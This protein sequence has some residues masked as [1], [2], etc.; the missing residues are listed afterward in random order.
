MQFK[1]D[2]GII[3]VMGFSMNTAEV[4]DFLKKVAW[5]IAIIII[6]KIIIKVGN[7]L[8][9][10]FFNKQKNSRFGV[11]EKKAD[12]LSELL[13]S[14]LRYVMYLLAV[15]WTISII[16]PGFA[17]T[18]TGVLG[19]GGVAV[20]FGAQSLIKDIISGFF[21]LFEDQFAVGDY[22]QVDNMSGFVETLG[23]R[24]TKIRDFTGDLHIIPNG[25]ITKVTNK[26]RGNMRALVDVSISY[27]DDIDA[28]IKIIRKV[29]EEAKND[30]KTITDGPDVL[31][32]TE[33][34]ELGVK[35]TVVAKTIPMEQ[36]AVERE[37][38]KR[39]KYALDKEG[40]EIPYQKRVVINE[41]KED[42]V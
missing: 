8:I 33:L 35:I 31:G 37:L 38:R 20:G 29:C 17:M 27:E 11:S 30:I 18:L 26:S 5:I 12:T 40:I 4:T 21:I 16:N 14:I 25:A 13:K 36:W 24:I 15:M 23:L 1:I 6:T 42:E 28:A 3:E 7:V 10:K 39:I 22:I 19:V 9:E 32:V 2:R 41:T 34:G